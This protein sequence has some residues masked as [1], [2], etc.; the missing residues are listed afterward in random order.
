MALLMALMTSELGSTERG[1]GSAERERPSPKG[2][3][4]PSA[5]KNYASDGKTLRP[6]IGWNW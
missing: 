3:W 6:A 5:L 1:Q 2:L 4:I